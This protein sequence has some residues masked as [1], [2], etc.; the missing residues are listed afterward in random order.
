MSRLAQQLRD[1]G[2]NA[3]A[4]SELKQGYS[5]DN[6]PKKKHNKKRLSKRRKKGKR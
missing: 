6:P 2:F 4:T 1:A 5:I 3:I